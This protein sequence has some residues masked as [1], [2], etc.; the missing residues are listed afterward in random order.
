[1]TDPVFQESKFDQKNE[2][3]RYGMTCAPQKK[4]HVPRQ[5]GGSD[6]WTR[7][8]WNQRRAVYLL[9]WNYL[10]NPNFWCLY[11]CI[12]FVLSR[13][14]PFSLYGWPTA[15][16]PPVSIQYG[17]CR[18]LHSSPPPLKARVITEWI[19]ISARIFRGAFSVKT[20]MRSC[21]RTCCFAR[22]GAIRL[23]HSG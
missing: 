21:F 12:Y 4:Y 6:R 17:G 18:Y 10:E 23:N 15:V 5:C 2:R 19:G 20:N 16:I 11:F 22:T 1:M 14:F 8:P 13:F 9:S 3:D 7:T